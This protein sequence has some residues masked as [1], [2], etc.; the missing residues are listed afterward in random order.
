MYENTRVE[1][2]GAFKEY[3][4][5]MSVILPVWVP[6]IITLTPGIS[7]LLAASETVPDT[8]TEVTSWALEI[9][10][11][12]MSKVASTRLNRPDL[13]LTNRIIDFISRF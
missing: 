12:R 7:S 4:P 9:L 3:F 6:L 10:A 2:F 13:C 11:D 8:L 1:P 5:S